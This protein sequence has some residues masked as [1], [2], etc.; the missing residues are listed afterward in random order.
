MLENGPNASMKNE[1]LKP[2]PVKIPTVGRI[3][4]SEEL[5]REEFFCG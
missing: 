2:A 1:E 3:G 5:W 4:I